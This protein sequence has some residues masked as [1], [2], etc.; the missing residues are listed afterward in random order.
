[1]TFDLSFPKCMKNGGSVFFFL[2]FCYQRYTNQEES[3]KKIKSFHIG[4]AI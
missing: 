1:M 2:A 4:T 3:K